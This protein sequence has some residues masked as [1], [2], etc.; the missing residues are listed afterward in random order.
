LSRF[1]LV[2]CTATSADNAN[3]KPCVAGK[4]SFM[5]SFC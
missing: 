5:T 3:L 2:S 1:P 4:L